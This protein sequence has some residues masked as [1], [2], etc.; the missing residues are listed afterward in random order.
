[1]NIIENKAYCPVFLDSDEANLP[2]FS[3]SAVLHQDGHISFLIIN[4]K[5][6]SSALLWDTIEQPGLNEQIKNF[7]KETDQ[8][9]DKTL[10]EIK[11]TITQ[12]KTQLLQKKI[13]I[14]NS[15][16]TAKMNIP[17]GFLRFVSSKNEFFLPINGKTTKT[18]FIS[19]INLGKEI[20][21]KL[22]AKAILTENMCITGNESHNKFTSQNN[23]ILPTGSYEFFEGN[24]S[25]IGITQNF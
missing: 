19:R 3:V 7:L 2:S 21:W 13:S 8:D 18:I 9:S 25:E 5:E 24:E 16:N 14:L 20:G 17:D 12:V 6:N 23:L 15:C 1:M 22:I 4:Q 11:T 10:S